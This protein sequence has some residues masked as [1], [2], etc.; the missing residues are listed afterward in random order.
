MES[1]KIQVFK[2]NY[3]VKHVA[4]KIRCGWIMWRETTRVIKILLMVNGKFFNI[5]V[6]PAIMNIEYLIKKRYKN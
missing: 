1:K 2:V 3:I 6:S 4:S 5:V